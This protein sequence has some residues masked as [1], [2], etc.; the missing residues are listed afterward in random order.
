MRA[1][2]K[3]KITYTEM[4]KVSVIVDVTDT[5]LNNIFDKLG[6]INSDEDFA[7]GFDPRWKIEEKAYEKYCSGNG[8]AG[9][10]L[11]TDRSIRRCKG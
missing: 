6:V 5:G 10:V 7:D 9:D 8:E 4:R 1:T 11:I 3:Y 2:Y